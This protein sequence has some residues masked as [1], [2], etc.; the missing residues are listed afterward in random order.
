MSIVV[1]H[2]KR[3]NEILEKALDVF[4][5]EGFEETTFQKI[6]DRCQITRTTLYLYFKNKKEIFNY[7]TKL[8]LLKV[9]EGVKRIQADNSLSVI[10]KITRVMIDI[11]TQLQKNRRILVVVLNYL[12]Y[13][14]RSNTDPDIRVRRRTIRLRHILSSMIIEGVKKKEISPINI[15]LADD[16]LYSFFES[17]IFRLVILQ[18]DTVDELKQAAVYAVQR[19]IR[20]N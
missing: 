10:E 8:M 4:M 16:Y 5:D 7:S 19:L 14:S 9:E 1:E 17:A 15:K 12:L 2:D 18:H 11:I 20:K 3:R 6:A 13:L